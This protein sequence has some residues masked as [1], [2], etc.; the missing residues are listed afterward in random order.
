MVSLQTT[1]TFPSTCLQ[2]QLAALSLFS[3]DQ[4]LLVGILLLPGISFGASEEGSRAGNGCPAERHRTAPSPKVDLRDNPVRADTGL[5]QRKE[6]SEK[7]SLCDR[8]RVPLYGQFYRHQR[9]VSGVSPSND[10]EEVL[11]P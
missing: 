7:A 9:P 4:S 8:R 2:C 5:D 6:D 11:A 3:G 1:G 10:C